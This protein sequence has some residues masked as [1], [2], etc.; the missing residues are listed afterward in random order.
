MVIR[1]Q[2]FHNVKIKTYNTVGFIEILTSYLKKNRNWFSEELN[3]RVFRVEM[4]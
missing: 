1:Q 3:R 4:I 2:C